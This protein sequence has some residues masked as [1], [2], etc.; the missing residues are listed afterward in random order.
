MT[1]S[2]TFV[3]ND[4]TGVAAQGRATSGLAFLRSIAGR[5]I[6]QAAPIAQCLGFEL[7]EV[8]QGRVVFESVPG[9]H[10]YNP[11]GGVHGG[12]IATLLDSAAGAAV[13]S[14]LP[15]GVGYTTLELKVSFMKPVT[16][17]TGVVRAEGTVVSQ[18]SRVA[19][20]EA[21]LVDAAGKVLA[22]ATSTCLI[23]GGK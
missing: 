1:R 11:L 4:P 17:Q 14:T 6:V 22:H 10:M 23:L 5:G 19:Y 21:R 15:E 20:S 7:V 12:V 3:W 2:R 13:H 9:E 8:E 18:G 16:A